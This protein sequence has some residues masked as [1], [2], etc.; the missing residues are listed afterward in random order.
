MEWLD[1]I[2]TVA[3]KFIELFASAIKDYGPFTLIIFILVFVYM[4]QKKY[5]VWEDWK[6]VD[7]EDNWIRFLIGFIAATILSNVVGYILNIIFGTISEVTTISFGFWAAFKLAP[8]EFT[9]FF[10]AFSIIAIIILLIIAGGKFNN[11]NVLLGAGFAFVVLFLTFFSTSIYYE[12][13]G[14][15]HADEQTAKKSGGTDEKK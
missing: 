15:T 13:K 1:F 14:G 9:L 8:L 4:H 2:K 11:V 7:L 10:I 3:E 6:I 5:L 12:I